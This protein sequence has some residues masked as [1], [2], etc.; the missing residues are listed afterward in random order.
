[1]ADDLSRLN[2]TAAESVEPMASAAGE[3]E[4]KLEAEIDRRLE[5]RFVWVVLTMILAD[6][7]MFAHVDNW[8]GPV[9][10]GVLELIL[11]VVLARKWGIEEVS[12]VL[13]KF[14]DRA[15]DHTDPRKHEP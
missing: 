10:I 14:L 13:A 12:Q 8:A 7:L 11:L 3:L 6:T 5:E 15:A 9:V 1:M 2:E 4:N